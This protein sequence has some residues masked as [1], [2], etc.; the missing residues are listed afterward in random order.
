MEIINFD[1]LLPQKIKTKKNPFAP[2]R[3]FRMLM[4]GGSGSGKTNVLVNMVLRFLDYDKLYIYAKHLQQDKFKLVQNIINKIET[5]EELREMC[6]PPIAVFADDIK[7]VVPLEQMDKEKDNLIIFDDFV[8]EKNQKQIEDMFVRGRHKNASVIYLT[9][10]YFATPKTIRLNCSHFL[11]F[12]SPSNR[13]LNMVLNDHCSDMDKEDF[14]EI[15][16]LAVREPYNFF[17]VDTDA[18]D[19]RMKFRKNFDEFFSYN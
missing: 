9:Q 16:T 8:T 7:N 18:T 2:N 1:K 19:K 4:T 12:G 17:Y 13:D 15:Y 6:D 3:P 5:N 14:K 10:S 11:L